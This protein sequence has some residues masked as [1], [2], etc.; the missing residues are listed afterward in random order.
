MEKYIKELRKDP[1]VKLIWLGFKYENDY[2][3][4]VSPHE[5]FIPGDTEASYVRIDENY[6]KT[7][8]KFNSEI[9]EYMDKNNGIEKYIDVSKE[10]ISRLV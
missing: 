9:S 1:N 5:E 10:E 7:W 4:L 8:F 2:I 6:N 3:F